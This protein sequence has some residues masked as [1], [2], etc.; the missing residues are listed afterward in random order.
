MRAF[1]L[2]LPLLLAL[3]RADD[4]ALV[5]VPHGED[6]VSSRN[7]IVIHMSNDAVRQ[8]PLPC[9]VADSGTHENGQTFTKGH[10][11]YACKNGTAE[12]IACVS[13]DSSVI[14]IGRQLLRNGTRHVCGVVGE[15]VTYEQREQS[16]WEPTQT[17]ARL[18]VLRERH[19]L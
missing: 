1:F 11:H 6:P 13:A 2:A 17:S 12:V 14:Q 9:V 18:D 4:E 16:Y 3:A 10:F 5:L 8:A 15:T 19:P 7:R